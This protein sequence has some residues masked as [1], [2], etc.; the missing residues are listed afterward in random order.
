MNEIRGTPPESQFRLLIFGNGSVRTVPL[1]GT[2]WTIGRGTDCSIVL[3]DPTVSRKHL[4]ID[5]TGDT[6]TFRDLGGSNPV[7][8]D[9]RPMRHGTLTVGSSLVIG[10]TRLQLEVRMRPSEITTDPRKTIVL[11]REVLDPDA[12]AGQARSLTSR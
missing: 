10:L 8:L 4:Q 12:P 2:Q 7:Q 1:T 3:R 5:R 11:S 9:G 6:F